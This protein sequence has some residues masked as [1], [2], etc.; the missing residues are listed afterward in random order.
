MAWRGARPRRPGAPAGTR[1]G[2]SGGARYGGVGLSTV[3]GTGAGCFDGHRVLAV[4]KGITTLDEVRTGFLSHNDLMSLDG[5]EQ[6]PELRVLSVQSNR[7]A[8]LSEVRVLTA[9]CP[10]LEVASFEGNPLEGTP[11][12][13]KHLLG[14]L[15]ALKM[16]DGA[17]ATER[18]RAEARV[19]V[20][21]EAHLMD[22]A[23]E[24]L[25]MM[26]QLE[27]LTMLRRV[28]LDMFRR[29]GNGQR[30][31]WRDCPNVAVP[32]TRMFLAQWD[33]FKR[34]PEAEVQLMRTEIN[35]EVVRRYNSSRLRSGKRVSV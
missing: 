5:I 17:P 31:F 15:P 8:S 1:P 4:E 10:H 16:L 9:G 3:L 27:R 34:L 22:M 33:F 2:G 12:Y 11:N 7:I 32:D 29:R 6:F 28:H 14:I 23:L 24:N 25:G 20:S 13:R 30:L 18:E 21:Q 19:A 26:H 35:A